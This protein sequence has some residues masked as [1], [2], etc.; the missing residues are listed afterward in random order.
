MRYFKKRDFENYFD[1]DILNYEKRQRKSDSFHDKI[2]I[3]G[4]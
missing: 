3:L 4:C 2:T 1:K